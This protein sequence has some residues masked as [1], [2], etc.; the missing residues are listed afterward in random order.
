MY[1]ELA[2]TSSVTIICTEAHQEHPVYSELAETSSVTIICTEAHQEHSVYSELAETSSV[3]IWHGPLGKKSQVF[4]LGILEVE[5]NS[6]VK[7][8]HLVALGTALITIQI[9]NHNS[10]MPYMTQ[11]GF[12]QIIAKDN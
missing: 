3:T 9:Q 12:Q 6:Q 10:V 1:S 11:T 8:T 2:E 7:M 5:S 4:T